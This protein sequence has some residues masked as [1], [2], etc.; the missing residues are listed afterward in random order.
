[1]GADM[2]IR[3]VLMILVAMTLFVFALQPRDHMHGSR[4]RAAESVSQVENGSVPGPW[5]RYDT[6][7]VQ[8]NRGETYEEL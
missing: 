7:A 4:R 3:D 6:E 2:L 5:H 8:D 1:M